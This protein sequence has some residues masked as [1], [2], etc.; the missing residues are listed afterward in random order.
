MTGQISIFK[1]YM[2]FNL[3]IVTSLTNTFIDT[4][5]TTIDCTILRT[6]DNFDGRLTLDISG[7]TWNFRDDD[8]N[9]NHSMNVNLQRHEKKSNVTLN[10]WPSFAARI[11]RS[12]SA[13]AIKLVTTS[14]VVVAEMLKMYVSAMVNTA[15]PSADLQELILY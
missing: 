14:P 15:L 12:T 13:L 3:R 10:F 2:R 11:I 5:T 4:V 9:L 8:D 7:H 6:H 1:R